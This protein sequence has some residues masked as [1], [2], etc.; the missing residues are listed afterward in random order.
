METPIHV[1]RQKDSLGIFTEAQLKV[2]LN[3]GSIT[4]NDYCWTAGMKEWQLIGQVYPHLLPVSNAGSPPPAAPPAPRAPQAPYAQPGHAAG[5]P[6]AAFVYPSGGERFCAYMLD[7]TFMGLMLCCILVPTLVGIAGA[8]D[9][10]GR[11]SSEAVGNFASLLGTVF[12]FFGSLLYYGIQGNSAQ[13]ATWGQRI[14]GFKMVDAKTGAPP[15][16]GQVWQWA[17][18]RSLLLSCCGC[19]SFLFFIPIL[20][21]PQ[22]QSE[23]DKWA[24]ILMVKK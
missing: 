14:M 23:F 3:R 7:A 2:A 5:Y 21:N 17:F 19:F 12:G 24:G 8:L 4:E 13:N 6:Q 16:S 1:S 20:S 10:R 15:Q 11:D 22:K 9:G 18:F